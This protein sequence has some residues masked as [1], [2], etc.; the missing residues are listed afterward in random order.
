MRYEPLPHSFFA[1]NRDR[2]AAKLPAG[3]IIVLH[4]NDVMP[5]NAD[6][7]MAFHQNANLFYLCGIDQEETVLMMKIGEGGTYEATLLLRETNDTIAIWE[8]IRLSMEEAAKLSGISD[9]RWTG[10]YENCLKEYMD[11]A[12]TVFLESNNHP[13]AASP[14]QTRNVRFSLETKKK[15]P[16]K[17]Y[18]NIYEHVAELRLI[19]QPAEITSLKKACKITTEGF[20]ELLN[21]IKPGKGEW[22]IE[23]KLSYEYIRRGARKFSFLPIIASGANS[24][25]LHHIANNKIIQDGELVLLDIGAEYGY[26]NADMTRTIPANGKFTTRQRQVYEAVLRTMEYA[27]TILR[28]GIQ[29]SE[30]ERKVRVH[31]AGELINLGLLNANDLEEN[32]NDPPAVRKYFMHGGSHSLG[33]DV[34]DVGSLDPVIQAGMVFTIEPGIY[35]R[36]E[37]IGIRLENNYLVTDEDT[38]NLMPDSPIHPD[39]IEKIMAK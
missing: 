36:E 30:Y 27:R 23:A 25:V 19:K 18:E 16:S 24:C 34:H 10:E 15:Y 22:E 3:S 38:I 11:T 32:P 33:L 28:P 20:T 39:E 6:G 13:R 7:A 8:G 14:V 29:K 21:Y 2:L 12:Q 35:I 5:T 26:Y 37:S 17:T 4:S 31:M 9:I 1:G